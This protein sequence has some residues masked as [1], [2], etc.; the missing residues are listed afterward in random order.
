MGKFSIREMM[1]ESA[2]PAENA[3]IESVDVST[4]SVRTIEQ[5]TV[6]INFYKQQTVQNII[7]IGKR[8]IEAKSMLQHG[9]WSGWLQ[10]HVELTQSTANRF[11]QLA[12][13]FS[14]SAP[15]R[16]LN[17]SQMLALI[18]IPAEEREQFLAES[19]LVNG[20]PKTVDE[21]SKRELEQAIRERD[22]AKKAANEARETA[23]QERKR[24]DA[25]KREA[26]NKDVLYSKTVDKLE[27]QQDLIQTLERKVK[28]LEARPVEVA[29]QEIDE[30]ERERIREELRAELTS[31]QSR[32]ARIEFPDP[33]F[34]VGDTD[35]LPSMQSFAVDEEITLGAG[36]AFI[37][38]LQAAYANFETVAMISD[39]QNIA[40]TLSV[41]L[42]ATENM[43]DKLRSLQARVDNVRLSLDDELPEED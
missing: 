35:P 36:N 28:D 26:Q 41:C 3:A 16:N 42:S 29:V 40:E 23:E 7:E 30:A 14:N 17:Y 9:E 27:K 39:P 38:A 37:D 5:V 12:R 32:I 19:H 22:E 11:M 31:N 6:E 10:D 15:V 1:N 20:R 4:P 43:L 8:L 24:A 2:P 34:C 13:E 18:Q 25:N 21:M 33:V